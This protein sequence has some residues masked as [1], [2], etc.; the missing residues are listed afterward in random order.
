VGTN[1]PTANRKIIIRPIDWML[2]G[3]SIPVTTFVLSQFSLLVAHH[4][5]LDYNWKFELC[6]V[7]GQL[8][9]QS[10]FIL[11]RQSRLLPYAIQLLK[12]SLIGSVL[13]IPMLIVTHYFHL[14]DLQILCY[15]F[16]VVS[17]MFFVH[18]GMVKRLQL[19]WYM[20]YTWVAYRLVILLFIVK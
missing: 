8:L 20:C 16:T 4:L 12:V 19:P 14:S 3:L 18:K 2:A 17:I 15:F 1:S 9:F 5:W 11:K 10:L 13:L 7:L 6:M